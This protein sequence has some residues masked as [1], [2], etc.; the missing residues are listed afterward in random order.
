MMKLTLESHLDHPSGNGARVLRCQA[1]SKRSGKQCGRMANS[2]Y[3]V[4]AM[5]G[6]GT[7]KRVKAGKRKAAGRPPVLDFYT[8]H[9]KANIKK[10][11]QSAAASE[12]ELLEVRTELRILRATLQCNT[13]WPI[14]R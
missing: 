1:M 14:S 5:H 10:A 11:I 8:R 3:T 12:A 4:C 2:G 9:G 13:C 7:K 6:A